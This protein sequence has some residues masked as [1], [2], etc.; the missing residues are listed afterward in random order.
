VA[1]VAVPVIKLRY[2]QTDAFPNAIM[3]VFESANVWTPTDEFTYTGR[4]NLTRDSLSSSKEVKAKREEILK[5]LEKVFRERHGDQWEK[6]FKRLAGLLR[7]NDWD[8]SFFV[9]CY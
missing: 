5:A 6:P 8:L 2:R 7:K 1:R 4:V 9:D 3:D